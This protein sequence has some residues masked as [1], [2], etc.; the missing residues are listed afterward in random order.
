MEP[1]G[2]I[3][4]SFDAFYTLTVA[5]SECG[6]AVQ[7]YNCTASNSQNPFEGL[8]NYGK[9]MEKVWFTVIKKPCKD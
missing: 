4:K 3:P 2:R 6:G 1:N 7:N 8:A 9:M 5:N